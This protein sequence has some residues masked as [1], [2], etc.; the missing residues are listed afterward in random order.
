MVSKFGL[1]CARIGGVFQGDS[2]EFLRLFAAA[3]DFGINFYDTADMYAQGESEI[4]LGRAF[5]KQRSRVIIASKAGYSLPTRR[6]LVT[7][8]KPLLK[9]LIKLLKVRRDQL[10]S[11]ARGVVTQDFSAAY[12]RKAVEGSLRRLRTD[13]LDLFQ[14]HSVPL[15]VVERGEWQPVLEELKQSGKI[16]YYG[17]SVDALPAGLAGLS[18]TGVSSLQCVL[19]LLEPG[20]S[21]ALIPQ[22]HTRRVGIIARECLGNGLLIKEQNEVD[23]Q[24]Y[25][26][27]AEEVPKRIRQLQEFRE[28]A[29]AAGIALPALALKYVSEHAGVSVSLLGARNVDQLRRLL[30]YAAR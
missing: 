24:R 22:A 10:P 9:P 21:E 8:I 16:R 28:Q 14:L 12:L 7:R 29:A 26:S 6:R 5:R 15:D 27:T 1:G 20:S 23:L 4:L 3:A 2:R 11:G 25:C 30:G 13:Y 18:Y 19:S 17:L